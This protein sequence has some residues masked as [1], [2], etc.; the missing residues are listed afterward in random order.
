MDILELK[1]LA[2]F[3]FFLLTL[4]FGWTPF[5]L[6]R[7]FWSGSNK[8]ASLLTQHLHALASGV[9]LATCLL[10]LLPESVQTVH[11]ALA[12][13]SRHRN[14]QLPNG[15]TNASKSPSISTFEQAQGNDI[16]DNDGR[17][18][19]AEL[20]V[21]M[22]FLFIHY[23]DKII[24]A[25]QSFENRGEVEEAELDIAKEWTGGRQLQK[26]HH[27]SKQASDRDNLLNSVSRTGNG[28]VDDKPLKPPCENSNSIDGEE[29]LREI[30]IFQQIPSNDFSESH[31]AHP[32]AERRQMENLENSKSATPRVRSIALVA[33][34]CIHG[35]FDGVLLGL[36]TS[37]KVLLSLLLALSLH[38]SFV[39]V[40]LSLTLGNNNQSQITKKS[41]IKSV[42]TL[43]IF[44]FSCAAPLG[45]IVS[46][47]F[48]HTVFDP[49]V[50]DEAGDSSISILPGCLQSFAV[51]TFI[52]VTFS[53][54]T[55]HSK[56]KH[57]GISTDSRKKL[58]LRTLIEHTFLLIGFSLM[59]T[60]RVALGDS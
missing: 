49:S 59:A 9:L 6:L 2:G 28:Y 35:F 24:K 38:K 46:S 10:H 16:I 40:S 33:A 17:H 1:V 54:L 37:E 31:E 45:L 48:V 18:P 23:V 20:M 8:S 32:L 4:L 3:V 58:L 19:I 21:A 57:N 7:S 13:R 47:V 15:E 41:P 44:L 39:A 50:G 12:L 11:H 55:E 34:L 5:V 36:Q 29:S 30:C 51:G 27:F 22:G 53:E 42:E 25:W 52:Y 14:P 56:N 60:L 43:Y 26:Q